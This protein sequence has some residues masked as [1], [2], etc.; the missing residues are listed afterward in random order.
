MSAGYLPFHCINFKSF[1]M[2]MKFTPR[3]GHRYSNASRNFHIPSIWNVKLTVGRILNFWYKIVGKCERRIGFCHSNKCIFAHIVS[4]ARWRFAVESKFEIW[5]QK[6]DAVLKNICIHMVYLL[7]S[8]FLSSIG[9]HEQTIC[10]VC[11]CFF[12]FFSFFTFFS[13]LIFQIYVQF[14]NSGF[15]LSAV[16]VEYWTSKSN[17]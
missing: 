5:K 8:F 4:V 15:S 16:S 1:E 2:G 9:W 6:Q 14:F 12:S 13:V 11:I 7:V 3:V 10:S 17:F